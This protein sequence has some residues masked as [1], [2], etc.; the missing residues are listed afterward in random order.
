MMVFS[1]PKEGGGKLAVRR[2][3]YRRNARLAWV[4]RTADATSRADRVCL[5]RV[6]FRP[7][8]HRPR[9]ITEIS[10][11]VKMSTG[12]APPPPLSSTTPGSRNTPSHFTFCAAQMISHE[13]N[14]LLT[15]QTSRQQTLIDT[16]A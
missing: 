7:S 2:D 4:S 16:M 15:I 10:D 3:T 14:E 12:N 13:H 9:N 11:T 6:H 8:R 1:Q 5:S